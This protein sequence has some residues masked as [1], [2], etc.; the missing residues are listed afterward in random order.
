[1]TSGTVPVRL[2]RRSADGLRMARG[3][4]DVGARGDWAGRVVRRALIAALGRRSSR[5]ERVRI[6]RIEALRRELVASEELIERLD[7]GAGAYAPPAPEPYHLGVRVEHTIGDFC[8]RSSIG[9]VWSRLLFHLVREAGPAHAVELGTALGISAAYQGAALELNGHG[10]LVTIEGSAPLA[11]MAARNLETLAIGSVEVVTGTFAATLPRVLD[12]LGPLDFAYID[13][14]HDGRA[15][16]DYFGTVLSAITAPAIVVFDDIGISAG[17]R[18]A[19]TAISRHP[20]VTLAVDV[21]K[22][23]VCGIA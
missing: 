10:R 11:R 3:V 18:E 4:R 20:R 17:M 6:A 23:G 5:A 16:L 8:R 22:L 2:R 9:P 14:H 7:F 21:H 19:W 12:A 15:T 1:M 13:G